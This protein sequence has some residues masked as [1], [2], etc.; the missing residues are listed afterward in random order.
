MARIVIHIGSHKTGTT[1]LQQGFVALRQPLLAVGFDDPSEWQDHLD[2][3]DTL[4]G[5]AAGD[6]A[7]LARLAAIGVT[8]AREGR[9]VLLSSEKFEHLDDSAVGRLAGALR[10][11][12]VEIV[13][14]ARHWSGLL[15][16]AWQEQIKQGGS[17][18]YPEFLLSHFA[19]PA[20]SRLP[21]PMGVLGRY[22]AAFGRDAIRLV[23]D[24]R[25]VGGGGDL[26]GLVL[27]ALLRVP[28]LPSSQ[29]RRVNAALAAVE[30][31]VIRVVN[32]MAGRWPGS[33]PGGVRPM[34][35]F[36][37]FGREGL[38]AID[39]QRAALRPYVIRCGVPDDL[40]ALQVIES[41]TIAQSVPMLPAQGDAPARKPF[42]AGEHVAGEYWIDP[43]MQT[44]FATRRDALGRRYAEIA[45]AA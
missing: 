8:A 5:L 29:G 3:H 35:L 39:T 22:A 32:A 14:V 9:A 26:L 20:D 37:E 36:F 31:E 16:S 19:Q 1:Y 33:V 42:V 2:G 38:P 30:V 15:P 23:D 40:A 4:V 17:E 6:G 34:K 27:D 45:H 21:S 7:A 43:T 12:A 41:Q 11:H 28:V 44:A 24:D 10:G 25:L 13:Y 18:T